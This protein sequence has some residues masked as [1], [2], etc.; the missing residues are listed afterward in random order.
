[1]KKIIAF[2]PVLQSKRP[3]KQEK[4]TTLTAKNAVSRLN[5]SSQSGFIFNK[6]SEPGKIF[7]LSTRPAYILNISSYDRAR[8]PIVYMLAPS[9]AR[10]V[11]YAVYVIR[12]SDIGPPSL[13]SGF[14]T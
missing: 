7:I 2:Y 5:L 14:S 6:C 8:M 9:M 12:I 10:L 11:L 13:N 1:M 4:E 3:D